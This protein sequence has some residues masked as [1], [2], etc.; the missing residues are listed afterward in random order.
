[1]L[2]YIDRSSH[3][4]ADVGVSPIL[5]A[6]LGHAAI[7][8]SAR[9]FFPNFPPEIPEQL[10]DNS[11]AIHRFTG[12]GTVDFRPTAWFSNRLVV[13][14]DYTG[15]DSRALERF[16]PPALA[17]F[18]PPSVAAGRITQTLRNNT[19]I[20]A[21]YSGT[22]RVALTRSLSAASS[23]GGQF[24]RT[25]LNTST[26]GGMSFPGPKVETV[27]AT[28]Q[29]FNSTQ[30]SILN[31]TIGAYAQ[32]QFGWN[33]RLF[34]TAAVRVDNNS[35]FGNDFKWVTYPKVSGSWV[36][37]E[38]PFWHVDA[39]NTLK[40]RAAYG[41]SGRQPT[42]Y[43]ALRT[44]TP[45]SG[46]DGTNGVT[47]GSAG[48]PNLK[49]ERGKEVEVGFEG[50]FF[51]RLDL[52]FT[53]FDKRTTDEIVQQPI[54]PSS[55]FPG[56]QF[57]NLGK[58]TNHGIELQASV[59][60]LTGTTLAWEITANVATSRDK[61]VDLGGQPAIPAPGQN[62]IAGYPIGGYFAKRVV[63]TDR[64]PATGLATN[65]LCDG[66]PGQAPMACAAAPLLFIG[67]PTPKVSGSLANTFTIGGRLR[68]YAMVDFKRGHRLFNATEQLR[69]DGTI[70]I[71]LCEANY[72]PEKYS[73]LYL[74]ELPASDNLAGINDQFIQD[75]SF[76]KLREVSASYTLPER[77]LR[78]AGVS[79]AVVSVAARELHTWTRYRG[80]DPEVNASVSASDPL[81][82]DQ[83]VIPPLSHFVATLNLTF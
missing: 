81:A 24:Y 62:N 30:T 47:P 67:T 32:E 48:N 22:A 16:A 3:L 71:G 78:R 8:P 38:E 39:I 5:G 34:L 65:I 68:L 52:D 46:P 79:R 63:Q 51:G 19:L 74:A 27:S 43:A 57:V 58:V 13:G 69:C 80:V 61:I 21:D 42:A 50:T 45:V 2:S 41:E 35:A 70:G 33:D 77:W 20:T 18:L 40:L 29:Q 26:L 49:P 1:S 15:D 31:T 6:E 82:Y 76:V 14:I 55:G 73:P 72:F 44:Y 12:S 66:G 11:Q 83:G 28:A 75:A 10:Y 60:A 36:V 59:Q 53:Y 17:A 37:S 64:D 25:Q 7:F 56:D 54:A 4:G 9:G 23:I